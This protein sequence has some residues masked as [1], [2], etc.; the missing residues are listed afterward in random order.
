MRTL[1]LL[2]DPQN[3][4]ITGTL[5]VSGAEQAIKNVCKLI[6]KN[7]SAHVAITVDW[8][9]ENHCSFSQ[10]PP[11]CVQNTIGANFPEYLQ[12]VLFHV[13]WDV[14]DK[15]TDS[16]KEEYSIF[17]NELAGK[18]LEELVQEY[19][20]I[21]VCGV[22]GDY[23]VLETLKDLLKIVDRGVITVYTEGIASIDGGATLNNFITE[24]HLRKLKI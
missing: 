14:F 13:G 1:I 20:E 10:W 12:E 2:V 18:E 21:I 11:H 9:P 4:F 22:A 5:A 19:D 8:H 17:Q 23:C 24:E 15:G 3:D 16:N 6:R 7:A